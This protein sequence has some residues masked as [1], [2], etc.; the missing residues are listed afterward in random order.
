MTAPGRLE[1][2]NDVAQTLNLK[3]LIITESKL[4]QTIS[5]QLIGLTGFHE[6]L[7]RDRDRNGGGCLVYISNN[8]TYVQQPKLQSQFFEHI[9]VDVRVKDK[10]YSINTLY[11]PPNEAAT[12]HE[13]FL[14][15]SGQILSS[16]TSHKSDNFVL[17]G[18]LNFGNVYCRFPV[19][20]PKPL[21]NTAPEL[22]SSFGLQQLIDI[23]TR[24]VDT[25]QSRSTSLIDLI[26]CR[27]TENIQSH[28]TLPPIADHDG[29]F[30]S[31]HCCIEK[32]KPRSKKV[33][34][35]KNLNEGELIEYIKSFDFQSAVLSKPI[36]EQAEAITKVLVE[37]FAKFVP[38]KTVVL[39][40]NDQPWVNS[41]TRLLLRKKNR[42]Y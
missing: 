29:V 24:V 36:S 17:A 1:A 31:F 19:L 5:N 22:F 12:D 42:N 35:Y 10:I 18:D 6:P 15:E 20:D 3:F 38:V 16:M 33:Y 21:D 39:R 28:G 4:D 30:V 27:E 23:P 32:V 8:L 37:A 11:R 7:R 41:Y 9:W 2:L 14:K 34:D 26:F 25:I 40:P 13:L